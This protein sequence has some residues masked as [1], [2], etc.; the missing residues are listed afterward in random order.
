MKTPRVAI[1]DPAG[2]R[3]GLSGALVLVQYTDAVD[4]RWFQVVGGPLDRAAGPTPFHP[5]HDNRSGYGSN[6]AG[7]TNGNSTRASTD[8]PEM[9]DY[10]VDGPVF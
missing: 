4:P 2:W 9:D 1:D 6:A 10:S 8:P 3:V 5:P 7:M